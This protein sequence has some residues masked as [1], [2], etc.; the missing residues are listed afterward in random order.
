MLHQWVTNWEKIHRS[1]AKMLKR[2]F[3][4]KYFIYISFAT[5]IL[6]CVSSLWSAEVIGNI[7]PLNNVAWNFGSCL[8]KQQETLICK[9]VFAGCSVAS[10][11]WQEYSGADNN[12]IGPRSIYM[13]GWGIYRLPV[14]IVSC[15][16]GIHQKSPPSQALP[17]PVSQPGLCS[18][19]HNLQPLT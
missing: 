14:T 17:N 2:P 19:H 3:T 5:L 1:T 11:G 7:V 18:F 9:N 4:M 15:H 13:S 16:L 8:Q 12:E 10:E 6:T